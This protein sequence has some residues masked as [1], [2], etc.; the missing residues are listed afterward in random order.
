MTKA[1]LALALILGL[2]GMAAVPAQA[3][4][5]GLPIPI[6]ATGAGTNFTGTFFLQNFTQNTAGQ[7]LAN[8]I[9]T[10]TVTRGTTTQTILQNV[11]LPVL[12]QLLPGTGA[13]CSILH[14]ELGPIDLNL[15]GLRLQT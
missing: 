7:I 3:Q 6:T 13:A 2:F 8:G 1:I 12:A 9:V 15:L 14:L 4:V 5:P 10:G 11:A